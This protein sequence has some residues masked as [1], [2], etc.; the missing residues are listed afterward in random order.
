MAGTVYNDLYTTQNMSTTGT[1]ERD[2]ADT[3]RHI[4]PGA[5]ISPLIT[6]GKVPTPNGVIKSKKMFGKRQVTSPKFEAFVQAPLAIEFTVTSLS[7]TTL[8]LASTSGLVAKFSLV[9]TAN[10]TT[11]NIDSVTNTTTLEVTTYG[12]TAFSV[13]AGDKL[14]AISPHY[15]EKSSSPYIVYNDPENLYNLTYIFRHAVGISDTAMKAKHYG[16]NRYEHINKSNGAEAMRKASNALLFDNKPASSAEKTTSGLGTSF[17]SCDGLYQWA[18]TETDFGG[19]MTFEAFSQDMPLDFHESVGTSDPKLALMGY[20]QWSQILGW[21]N[22]GLLKLE[23]G[24][25]KQFGVWSEKIVT[26]RGWIECMVIDSF[27]RGSFASQ[28]LII[29]PEKVDYVF[30]EGRDMQLRKNIHDNSVDGKEDEIYGEISICPDDAGYS[31][32]KCINCS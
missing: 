30:L 22:A 2:V 11:C 6:S 18:Q 14:L 12:D 9:N 29:N 1:R 3:I 31:I 24:S 10:G 4:F 15:E 20:Q 25:Y 7:G 26:A 28:M 19:S 32:H 13:T 23:P 27:N 5:D 8:V 21:Q 16:G 17:G